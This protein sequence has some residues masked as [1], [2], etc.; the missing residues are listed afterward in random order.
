MLDSKKTKISLKQLPFPHFQYKLV[1]AKLADKIRKEILFNAKEGNLFKDGSIGRVNLLHNTNEQKKFLDTCLLTKKIIKDA[2]TF[3]HNNLYDVYKN[4]PL[5]PEIDNKDLYF[6]TDI[7]IA[8]DGYTRPAHL[9][10]EYHLAINFLYL[11]GEKEYGGEGGELQL[12]SPKNKNRPLFGDK[13]PNQLDLRAAVEIKP[14]PGLLVSFLRQ[15]N[16]WHSVKP[17]KNN[18][19]ERVFIFFGYDCKN[20]NDIWKDSFV[21]CES[22]REF[23]LKS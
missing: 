8:R 17:M 5:F 14:E 2:K 7:S 19:G 6:R 15:S 9:D 23:F 20:E 3:L 21:E 4:C 16:S 18:R 12:M 10:R 1:S 13:F 11:S 22:R